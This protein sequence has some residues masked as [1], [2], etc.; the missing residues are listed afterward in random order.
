MVTDEF[1]SIARKFDVTPE[2]LLSLAARQLVAQQP[3]S[4]TIL[5]AAPLDGQDCQKCPLLKRCGS[6]IKRARDKL[7]CFEKLP[8]VLAMIAA[9]L[10]MPILP[11]SARS[12]TSAPPTMTQPPFS[13]P[14][15]LPNNADTYL[16]PKLRAKF[17]KPRKRHKHATRDSN[18]VML[19]LNT[20][21][22]AGYRNAQR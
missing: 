7:V 3:E 17:A 9:L 15:S 11:H 22:R 12:V 10:A 4:L 14:I 2:M 19:A 6:A 20:L 1:L 21:V 16:K 18:P 5:S 13:E 8:V